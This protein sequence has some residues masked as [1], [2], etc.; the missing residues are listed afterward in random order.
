MQPLLQ[1]ESNEYYKPCVCVFVALCIQHAM[2]H[3]VIC[4]LTYSTILL[5]YYLINRTIFEK[6]VTEHKMCVLISSTTLV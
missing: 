2:C 6:K 1:W 4:G 3:T 5:P